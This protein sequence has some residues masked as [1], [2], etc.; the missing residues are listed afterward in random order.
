MGLAKHPLKRMVGGSLRGLTGAW[1]FWMSHVGH[2]YATMDPLGG[3]Q[4]R[5]EGNRV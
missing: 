4:K 3:S 1:C 5:S 2:I